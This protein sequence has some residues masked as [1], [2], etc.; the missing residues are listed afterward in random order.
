ML[1]L[2][3]QTAK[4]LSEESSIENLLSNIKLILKQGLQ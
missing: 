4:K 2:I 3:K 1:V